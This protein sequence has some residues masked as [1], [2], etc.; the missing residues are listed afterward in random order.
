MGEVV[1]RRRDPRI[2]VV[3]DNPDIMALMRE[4]LATRGY[5]VV[6]VADAAQAEARSRA[7]RPT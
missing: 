5:D 1:S 3:D 6:A 2:L 7:S 4:L